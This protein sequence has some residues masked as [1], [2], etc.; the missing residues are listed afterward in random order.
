MI[1]GWQLQTITKIKIQSQMNQEEIWKDVIGYEGAYQVSNL[2]RVKNVERGIHGASDSIRIIRERI[3]VQRTSR[4]G[5]KMTI[6]SKDNKQKNCTIHR[7][8]A[9]AFIPNPNNLPEV[10]HIDGDKSN[11]NS[12]NLE[13]TDRSGNNSHALRTGLRISCFAGKRGK[14][15]PDSKEVFQYDLEGN[16][17]TSFEST[18]EAHRQTGVNSKLISHCALGKQKYAGKYIWKYKKGA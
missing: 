1:G 15:H 10:N 9:L 17:I 7:L 6:L 14:L 2:G 11:N 13:W 5:Y 8:V 16:Y 4:N 18:C 3:R 12:S